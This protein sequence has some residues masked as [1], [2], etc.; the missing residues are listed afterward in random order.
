MAKLNPS[1]LKGATSK[2]GIKMPPAA[3]GVKAP[4]GIKVKSPDQMK[5]MAQ[6][7]AKA[8]LKVLLKIVILLVVVAIVAGIVYM[9][10]Y[11]GRQPKDAL[12][13]AI[14]YAYKDNVVRFRQSFTEDTIRHV[15]NGDEYKEEAW[16]PLI[17][18]ITPIEGHPKILDETIEEVNQKKLAKVTI[19]LDGEKR[20]VNMRQDDGKWLIDLNVAIDPMHVTL[21]EE[22]PAAYMKNFKLKD[23]HEPWW[24]DP[25]EA[26]EG[27]AQGF[28]SKFKCGGAKK[29]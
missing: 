19:L 7:K 29:K 5:K 11:Y 18:A 3:A 6:E 15:E 1:Q 24:E 26:S 4:A 13:N 12:E 22:I 9:V 10:K 25:P 27:T 8:R 2:A 17:N 21:P 23:T 14:Q 28:L 20:T 16:E